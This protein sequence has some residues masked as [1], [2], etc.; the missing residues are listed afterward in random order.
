MESPKITYEQLKRIDGIK[1]V[2]YNRLFENYLKLDL[3]GSKKLI[4]I[5]STDQE[6]VLKKLNSGIPTQGMIYTFIHLN[7]TNLSLLKNLKTG[8]EF[9]FHDLT[10]ILFCTN[11]D[12]NNKLIKGLNLNMLPSSERVKFFESYYTIYKNFLN[13][14]E[15]L[16]EYNEIAINY[17]YKI[18]AITGKNPALFEYFNKTQHALFNYA[19]RSYEIK[20]INRFRMIEYEQWQYI[21]FYSP[22]E[23]FKKIGIEL[24]HN[25]YWDNLN[26]TI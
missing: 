16:T 19:Y 18:A 14:I 1:D 20:N 8:K 3:K 4:D 7:K 24:I 10:P 22:K 13:K 26:K 25:T 21:P 11:Y 12:Y 9:E 2:A 17:E 5:T 15:E 23:A 6:S